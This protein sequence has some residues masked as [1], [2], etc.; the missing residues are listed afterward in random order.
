MR[1]ELEEVNTALRTIS[2]RHAQ[3]EAEVAQ[4]QA[5][6]ANQRELHLAPQPPRSYACTSRYLDHAPHATLKS[7]VSRG[8][9]IAS[10]ALEEQQSK[11]PEA[12]WFWG[13]PACL[14]VQPVQCAVAVTPSITEPLAIDSS[15]QGEGFSSFWGLSEAALEQQQHSTA[16]IST[17]DLAAAQGRCA[18]E[19]ARCRSAV[20]DEHLATAQLQPVAALACAKAAVHAAAQAVNTVMTLLHEYELLLAGSSDSSNSEAAFTVEALSESLSA[21]L[22]LQASALASQARLALLLRSQD[23]AAA[24]IQRAVQLFL[25][26]RS[27]AAE[28]AALQ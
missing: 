3:E 24:S 23:T 10:K 5:Q 8:A 17:A 19:T 25:A 4:L 9:L 14:V 7:G 28:R 16:S 21:A 6:N 1:R 13:A 15:L 12:S 18:V 11:E 22:Q 20:L 2:H 27:V 26:R